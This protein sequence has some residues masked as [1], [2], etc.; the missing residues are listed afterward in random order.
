MVA[1]ALPPPPGRAARPG[2]RTAARWAV[3]LLLAAGLAVWVAGGGAPRPEPAAAPGEG[4]AP[5]APAAAG[6]LL[7]GLE[8]PA[9][10]RDR[11]ARREAWAERLAHEEPEERL[12]ALA[13]ALAQGLPP[14]EVARAVLPLLGDSDQRVRAAARGLMHALGESAAAVLLVQGLASPEVEVPLL[15]L[16]VLGELAWRGLGDLER[17][18]TVLLALLADPAAPRARRERA[19]V[20]LAR[21]RPVTGEVRAAL[22][23]ALLGPGYEVPSSALAALRMLG[24]GGRGSLAALLQV[25]EAGHREELQSEAREA[26]ADLDVD[27]D[28][29]VER[30]LALQGPERGMAH[31]IAALR[32]RALPWLLRSL[33]GEQ[34]AT[35][36]RVLAQLPHEALGPALGAL[37]ERGRGDAEVG[38]AV[39]DQLQSV[40]LETR[41]HALLRAHTPALAAWLGALPEPPLPPPGLRGEQAPAAGDVRGAFE[42]EARRAWT[43]WAERDSTA[44][45]LVDLMQRAGSEGADALARLLEQGSRARRLHVL[46]RLQTPLGDAPSLRRALAALAAQ[47]GDAQ[48]QHLAQHLLTEEAHWEAAARRR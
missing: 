45:D 32:E 48:A 28:L 30:L 4:A 26:L 13:E 18:R 2:G 43:A 10:E 12:A 39:L 46:A 36:L 33:G 35:A 11:R 25:L 16:E 31:E 15:A 8:V 38:R 27:G 34:R 40:W 41:E 21:I 5:P 23:A 3:P 6:P 29:L 19:A 7:R 24:D 22:E 44:D 14:E 9:A 17:L 1:P 47:E 20:A 42:E 37:I